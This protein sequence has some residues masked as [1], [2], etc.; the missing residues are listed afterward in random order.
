MLA[1]RAMAVA[2]VEE[3]PDVLRDAEDALPALFA[4]QPPRDVLGGLWSGVK[5]VLSGVLIGAAG[6]V[7]QPIEASARKT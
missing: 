4:T 6:L 7:A 3:E 2:V 5:C 1:L